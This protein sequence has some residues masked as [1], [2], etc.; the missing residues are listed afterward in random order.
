MSSAPASSTTSDREMAKLQAKANL[1]LALYSHVAHDLEHTR[2][3]AAEART[4]ADLL[5]RQLADV[6]REFEQAHRHLGEARADVERV[7]GQLNYMLQ[8]RDRLMVR[9]HELEQL[10]QQHDALLNSTSW[11]ITAPIRAVARIAKRQ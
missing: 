5:R 3:E 4:E 9:A 10:Q 6:R 2:A 8:E 7:H 11:R 1:L